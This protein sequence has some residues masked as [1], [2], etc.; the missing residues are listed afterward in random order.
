MGETLCLTVRDIVLR[1][2]TCIADA[3]AECVGI[4]VAQ[5]KTIEGQF[6]LVDSL[7]SAALIEDNVRRT[8]LSN[9]VKLFN[10]TY[11]DFLDNSIAK[12]NLKAALTTQF[13]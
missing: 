6:P 3:R 8:K 9:N 10:L 1:D 12:L 13:F 7:Y 5:A 4:H 11:H 2:D